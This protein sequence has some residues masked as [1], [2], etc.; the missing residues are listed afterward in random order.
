MITRFPYKRAA[1]VYSC[2][3]I[4]PISRIHAGR[5]L[6]ITRFPYKRAAPVYSCEGIP[7]YQQRIMQ[8]IPVIAQASTNWEDKRKL[9]NKKKSKKKNKCARNALILSNWLKFTRGQE[10]MLWENAPSSC[11][12]VTEHNQLQICEFPLTVILL[13]LLAKLSCPVP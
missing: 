9:G 10:N 12:A 13:S 7:L 2:E 1:P 5:S 6:Q 3:G 8:T 4:P 11:G